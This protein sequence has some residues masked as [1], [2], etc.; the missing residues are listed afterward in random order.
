MNSK[1]NQLTLSEKLNYKKWL[2]GFQAELKKLPQVEMEIKNSFAPGVYARTIIMPA[3]T[4]LIGKTHKTD[5]FNIAHT[6][7][8]DVTI[9]GQ[10]KLVCAGDMFRSEPGSKKLFEVIEDM[11]FSTIHP[12]DKTD[13]DEIEKDTVYTDEEEEKLMESDIQ[14]LEK[15]VEGLKLEVL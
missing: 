6:G 13:I 1:S 5:H 2:V 3:G 7:K 12:T 15:E 8:A 10:T 4:I 11:K 14:A 9:D